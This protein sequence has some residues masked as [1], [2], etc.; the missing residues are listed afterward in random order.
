[1]SNKDEQNMAYPPYGYPHM[2]PHYQHPAMYPYPPHMHQ[3]MYPH[4][5]QQM[6]PQMQQMHQQMHQQQVPHGH[7]PH[8]AQPPHQGQQQDSGFDP[9][10]AQGQQMLEGL[11]G[12]QAGIF[13]DLMHKLGVDDKEFWK[14]A[15]IGAAA[16]L[17]L[18]NDNV[19][20]NLMNLVSGAGDMLKTGTDKVKQTATQTASSVSDNV[21]M[22]SDVFKDTFAAGKAGFKES[23]ER[24][25]Q[26]EADKAPQAAAPQAEAPVAEADAGN[27]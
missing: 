4:M 17:I 13:K 18:S 24:H 21:S 22:T 6:P 7:H 5:Q 3:P 14:G 19:R 12:E 2:H 16:A 15:M 10:M 20:G 23:V 26:P 27:E 1:M 8:Y 25:R 9:L 11:M